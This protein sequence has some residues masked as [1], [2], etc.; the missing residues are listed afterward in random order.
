MRELNKAKQKIQILRDERAI[1][2]TQNTARDRVIEARCEKAISH[3]QEIGSIITE[4]FPPEVKSLKTAVAKTRFI[5][6]GGVK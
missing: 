2:A 1:H 3:S 5:R 4:L 6:D